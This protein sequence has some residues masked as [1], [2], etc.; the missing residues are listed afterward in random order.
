M[1]LRCI[2]VQ[3]FRNIASAHLELEGGRQFFVG[4]NGQGK[5]NLIESVG[6]LTALRSFRTA[7]S[8]LLIRQG[9]TEAKLAF[10]LEHELQGETRVQI[11]IRHDG[12]E[13][14][15]DQEKIGRIADFLGKFPVVVLSSHDLQLVRGA[16]GD[17]R[18]WMDLTLSSMDPGYFAVLQTYHRVLSERNALLKQGRGDSELG[19]FEHIMAPAAMELMER[20]KADLARFGELL[21]LAYARI[22]EVSEP[23]SFS[24]E[25]D[26]S[27][28]STTAYLAMLKEGRERDAKMR[29]TARGPH[30]D[31]FTFQV[32]TRA[33]RDFASEGQQRLLVIALRLAQMEWFRMK[34]G[35]MPLIL[36][37]DVVGE[38]DPSRRARFWTAVEQGQMLAT[39][40]ERPL[41]T[42][43]D[44]QFFHVE[45]GRIQALPRE[46]RS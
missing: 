9:E 35:V 1:R 5:T 25:A 15:V 27:A 44:W 2:T 38:L 20:R 45:A 26:A 19:A 34:S 33:A 23:V 37:D 7:D 16:P 30:R 10:V 28:V 42:E 24:Y 39:G 11:T 40:T 29:T 31:D 22:A 21:S 17:R 46:A 36:A 13:L 3:N 41:R 12:K 14:W 8:K 4:D 43:G 6:L 18:R 32:H